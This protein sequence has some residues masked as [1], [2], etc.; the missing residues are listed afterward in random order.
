MVR[1]SQAIIAVDGS[2]GTLS[3]IGHALQNGIPV[4][5]LDTWSL[6]IDGKTDDSIIPAESPK[7][8]VSKALE[9]INNRQ[10]VQG[11]GGKNVND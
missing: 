9:L 7:E 8:A 1:S 4:I 11:T 6:A 10:Q 5:G 3:E 2:Y